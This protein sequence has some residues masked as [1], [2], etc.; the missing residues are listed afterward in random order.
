[1]KT[2]IIIPAYNEEGAIETVVK[3]LVNNHPHYDYVVVNDGS[4]DRTADV[5]RSKNFNLLDLPVTVGLSGA[6]QAGMKLAKTKNYDYAVQIDGDG[7]HMPLYISDL[8]AKMEE[9]GADIVIG[10][11]FLSN[12]KKLNSRALGGGII[13]FMLLLVSGTRLTDPTSGMRLYNKKMIREFSGN[14]NYSPEPDTIAY[15]IRNGIKVAEAKVEMKEREYGESYLNFANAIRYM[16]HMAVS[17]LFIQWFR[18]KRG[19]L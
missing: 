15:L 6:I 2:L 7:Q 13:K 18:K 11:R 16:L 12:K 14:I 1:M 8:F 4:W 5:C 17:I 3:D 19:V 9:V 10:S